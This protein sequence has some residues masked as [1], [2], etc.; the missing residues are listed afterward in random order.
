MGDTFYSSK[1]AFV[2]AIIGY[3]LTYHYPRDTCFLISK[4]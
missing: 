2:N 4:G 1:L 3:I